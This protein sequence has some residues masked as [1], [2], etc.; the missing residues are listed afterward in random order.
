[1]E[2]ANL[3]MNLKMAALK[4]FIS[5]SE[6]EE[7]QKFQGLGLTFESLRASSSVAVRIAIYLFANP[8]VP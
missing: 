8:V 4:R 2:Y 3:A 1:M 6:F 7:L 5:F